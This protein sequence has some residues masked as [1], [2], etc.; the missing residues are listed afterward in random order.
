[1]QGCDRLGVTCCTKSGHSDSRFQAADL[2]NV[3]RMLGPRVSCFGPAPRRN[4]A[5]VQH[6][7]GLGAIRM[8]TMH[9]ILA[10]ALI[11]LAVFATASASTGQR[12]LRPATA[13]LH[14]LEVQMWRMV[15]RDRTS[16]RVAQETKGRAYPL[17]WD[18]RLAAVARA[19]SEEMAA[20][21]SFSHIE[22]NGS[23]PMMRVSNAGIHWRAVGENIAKAADPAQAEVL[24]MDEP[25]FSE[26]HRGN[27]LNPAYNHIG[28]G[29]AR[30]ADGSLYITQEFAQIP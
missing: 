17:V 4:P 11:P 23:S 5:V 14:E 24:F 12:A 27:I 2:R 7:V 21:G 26:N 6:R 25:K 13:D 9:A 10:P 19:H 8:R 28:I 20:T 3:M 1:M 16:A 22:A 15:N 29:M 18:S 30:A